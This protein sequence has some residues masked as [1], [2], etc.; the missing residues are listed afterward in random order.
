MPSNREDHSPRPALAQAGSPDWELPL[1]GAR[2]TLAEGAAHACVL[3]VLGKQKGWRRDSS[4]V[5]SWRPGPGKELVPSPSAQ[6]W[7]SASEPQPLVPCW[8]QLGKVHLCW[9]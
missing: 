1:Q 6:A 9:G 2:E 8:G 7:D 3:L 4:P 5:T